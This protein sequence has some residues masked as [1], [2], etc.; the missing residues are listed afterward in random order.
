MLESICYENSTQKEAIAMDYPNHITDYKNEKRSIQS[1]ESGSLKNALQGECENERLPDEQVF[2]P[3][4]C[5]SGSAC[6]KWMGLQ[7]LRLQMPR[8]L[9]ARRSRKKS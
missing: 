8:E 5:E 4:Q 9:I 7:H 2:L 6:T 3:L 1:L